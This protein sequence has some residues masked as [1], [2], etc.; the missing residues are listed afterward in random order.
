[1]VKKRWT[2]KG[3]LSFSVV[4]LPKDAPYTVQGVSEWE[5]VEHFNSVTDDTTVMDDISNFSDQMP[6][7]MAGEVV[8]EV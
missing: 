4:A 3:M 1:M 6:I 8:F 2:E 7:F 5:S